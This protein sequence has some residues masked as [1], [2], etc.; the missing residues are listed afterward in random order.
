ME[1]VVGKIID[2]LWLIVAAIVTWIVKEIRELRKDQERAHAETATRSEHNTLAAIVA[3]TRETLV[4]REELK[5]VIRDF[6]EDADARLEFLAKQVS[7]TKISTSE[8][9]KKTSDFRHAMRNEMQ[10]QS[11]GIY[12]L[13]QHAGIKLPPRKQE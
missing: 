12:L 3:N 6:K 5:E 8:S 4:T 9:E 10:A 7:E 13:A 2:W 11:M 1:D